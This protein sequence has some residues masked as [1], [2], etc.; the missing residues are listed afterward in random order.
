[1]SDEFNYLYELPE[2]QEFLSNMSVVVSTS[3]DVNQLNWSTN[4]NTLITKA[5]I[6]EITVALKLFSDGEVTFKLTHKAL[7]DTGWN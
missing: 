4:T 1:M 2:T 3:N 6:L 5:I 7:I